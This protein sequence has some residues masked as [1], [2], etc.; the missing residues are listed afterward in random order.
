MSTAPGPES[1]LN[2]PTPPAPI[3]NIIA[4]HKC[5]VSYHH[6]MCHVYGLNL[7]IGTQAVDFVFLLSLS[8][9]PLFSV[10]RF[11]VVSSQYLHSFNT[12]RNAMEKTRSG[13]FFNNKCFFIEHMNMML[14]SL[15]FNMYTYYVVDERYLYL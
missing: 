8:F 6:V 2:R 5:T 7:K 13:F 10:C 3:Y 15:P 4:L 11:K 14:F 9:S 12:S 1:A